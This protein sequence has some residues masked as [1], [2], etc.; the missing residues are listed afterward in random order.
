MAVSAQ[1][2][3]DLDIRLRQP[4]LIW[5]FGNLEMV[6]KQPNFALSIS[7]TGTHLPGFEEA[8]RFEAK[9]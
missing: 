3:V 1:L 7:P 6:G 4:M 9:L 5:L 8:S 2:R